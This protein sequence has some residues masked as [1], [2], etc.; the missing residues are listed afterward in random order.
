MDFASLQKYYPQNVFLLQGDEQFA[1]KCIAEAVVAHGFVHSL[2]LPRFAIEHGRALASFIAEGTGSPRIYI[3][4]F[5]VF[6]PDAAQ[7]LLKSFE[8]GDSDTIVI[9]ITPYP[10]TVPATIRSRVMLVPQSIII[11]QQTLPSRDALLATIKKEFA[12]DAPEDAASRRAKAVALLDTL[13]TH[14]VKSPTRAKVVYDAKKMLFVAN[15]PT[16]FV[17]EYVVSVVV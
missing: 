5:S 9:L 16:K 12:S 7:V 1:H 11:E 8:E 13:E 17:L 4:F 14:C 6:S 10:Y 2:V 3:A 15:M